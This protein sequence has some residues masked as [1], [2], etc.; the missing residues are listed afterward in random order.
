MTLALNNVYHMDCIQ[1]M[2]Q[3]EAGSVDL[4][5]A[6]P[7]YY[8]I[9]GDFDWQWR[10][11]DAYLDWCKAWIRECAR[12]LS[13]R[14][15]IYVYGV[16]LGLDA[17][18]WA[19]YQETELEYRNRITFT[20]STSYILNRYGSMA[21]F[22]QYVPTTEHAVY[23]TFPD[24]TGLTLVKRDVNNFGE[25]R[26]YFRDLQ[27]AIGW[28]KK[29]IIDTVGQRADHAFR[30]SSS[31]WDLPTEETYHAIVCLLIAA[32]PASSIRVRSFEELQKRY[33]AYRDEYEAERQALEAERYTFN[34]NHGETNV[35]EFVPDRGRNKTAHPTQKPMSI[36]ERLIRNSSN[37]HD[38]ILAPFAG[39]GTELVAAQRM[40][41]KYIGFEIDERYYGICRNRLDETNG[42]AEIEGDEEEEEVAS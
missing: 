40:G 8:K 27:E 25:L 37:R 11:F 19:I 23:Y 16:D 36:T 42:A 7:P 41:R 3:L 29:A 12:V 13:P 34:A 17:I 18:S 26:Q 9:K 31:Q 4:I 20:K 1:G 39:S 21:H 14:G 10:T 33:S 2:R 24:K 38:T 22:R 30:H 15:S 28:T 35:W 6:D 32:N 5:I